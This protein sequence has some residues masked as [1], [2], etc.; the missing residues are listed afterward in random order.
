MEVTEVI[1]SVGINLL[2]DGIAGGF[3]QVAVGARLFQPAT[4]VVQ[5]VV[6]VAATQEYGQVEALPGEGVSYAIG[7]LRFG[8]SDKCLV[9]VVYF[10]VIVNVGKDVIA[11]PR[12][13]LGNALVTVCVSEPT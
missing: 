2:Y 10:P 1:R 7:E 5:Y 13:S 12:F 8:I 6:A 9:V 3:Q 4:G 11:Q